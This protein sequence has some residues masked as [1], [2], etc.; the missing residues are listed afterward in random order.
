MDPVVLAIPIFFVLIGAELLCNWL[1]T[2]KRPGTSVY[3]FN[4]AV[5]NI[6]CGVIDQVTGVFAKVLT[7]GIYALVYESVAIFEIP[8]HWLWF[9]LCFIG[10]DFCYYWSHRL[11]HDINIFWTGHVVHHQSEEYNLSVA[12]RQGAMQKVLMFWVYLPLA[13]VGFSPEWF[14]Y[15]IGFNLLYQFWIHTEA[16]DKMGW[17][18]LIFNTPSHHRVHHGRNPKYLDKN[19]AGVLI[20]WDKLF[21]TYQKEE[22]HPT[23][24]ITRPTESFNP[25]WAHVQPFSRLFQDVRSIPGWGDKLL[26]LLKPPGWYPKSMGGFREPGPIEKPIRKFN[27]ELAFSV[28]IYLLVQYALAIGLTAG[29]LFGLDMYNVF[30]KV[31][32]VVF[33]LF[34]V[35]VLGVIFDKKRSAVLFDILRIACILGAAV[36]AF[37]EKDWNIAALVLALLG[38]S[39]LFWL[40]RIK[41]HIYG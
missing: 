25:V 17:F 37:V 41:N 1:R 2:R 33:I 39:S 22:E 30:E 4:D 13:I 23:Y 16:I 19:H 6:S 26:F 29:F 10:V 31:L 32:F 18:E 7:V 8:G 35:L 36:Y 11:S 5:A 38:F 27:V 28:N 14:L 12:L 15:S 21:G 20:V 34:Y 24:G 40:L 3:R 9:V